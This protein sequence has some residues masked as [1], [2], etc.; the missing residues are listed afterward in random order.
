MLAFIE[1]FSQALFPLDYIDVAEMEQDFP[2][3]RWCWYII[4]SNFPDF[5]PT[6]AIPYFIGHSGL[7]GA[8]AFYSPKE[9]SI[10]PEL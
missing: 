10:S 7:S 5:D 6:G 1:A 2:P 3:M 8:L 9:I 4:C